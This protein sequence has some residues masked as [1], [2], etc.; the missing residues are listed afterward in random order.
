MPNDDQ[1]INAGLVPFANFTAQAGASYT[2]SNG[3]VVLYTPTANSVVTLPAVALGGPVRVVNLAGTYT[4]T[5]K[6]ADGSTVQGVAG[7]TG[8]VVPAG[9]TGASSTHATF[10]SNGTN[11]FVIAG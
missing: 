1:Y 5:V 7:T 3:D 9:G 4:V 2:A 11:W 10:V 8:Y 6:T